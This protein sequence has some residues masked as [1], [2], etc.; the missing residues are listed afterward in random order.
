MPPRNDEYTMRYIRIFLLH[1]QDSFEQR[2]RLF[3]WFLWSILNPFIMILYW[4]GA[5]QTGAHTWNYST[6]TSYYLL[7]LIAG[8]IFMSHTENDVG[9]EDI[10]EGQLATYLLKP[11]S[12]F[13]AKML[14]EIPNR[15][16]RGFMGLGILLLV[17]LFGSN[18]L[19]IQQSPL[20]ILFALIIGVLA[21]VLS[22]T[23]KMILGLTAFWVTD[24]GGLFQLSDMF[25][26]IFSG[27]ILPLSLLPKP[28][29]TIAYI[30]PYGYIIYFPV[31]TLQGNLSITT[32][33]QIIMSQ[34]V[35]IGITYALYRY[36]WKLGI[37]KF[38][39]VGQ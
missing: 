6:L 7:Q 36:M 2:S 37:R 24:I 30:L 22:F 19:H 29:E 8:E 1:L 20:G 25:I 5:N 26:F 16:V 9:Y 3:V 21:Y 35:W 39:A 28:W 32:L 13:K 10:Q 27:F 18:L 23:L 34:L 4:K 11:F 33:L 15:I 38:T 14:T 31:I 17:L 12:Y